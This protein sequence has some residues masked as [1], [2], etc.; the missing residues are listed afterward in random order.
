MSFIKNLFTGKNTAAIDCPTEQWKYSRAVDGIRRLVI[1]IKSEVV[2]DL[3]L[4]REKFPCSEIVADFLHNFVIQRFP[5]LS[6]F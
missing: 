2:E 4:I 1:D 5:I 6:L 3:S